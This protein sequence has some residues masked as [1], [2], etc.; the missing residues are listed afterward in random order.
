[1][2]PLAPACMS[3]A[4]HSLSD[5]AVAS[6]L[7][8]PVAM[9]SVHWLAEHDLKALKNGRGAPLAA[10]AL[11]SLAEPCTAGPP[12][13]SG[14]PHSP[15]VGIHWLVEHVCV[16]DLI[17]QRPQRV[18]LNITSRKGPTTQPST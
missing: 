14:L 12:G 5:I 10:F 13:S 8:M 3:L 7:L 11:A 4:G 1:M 16:D 17:L 15:Q 6:G 9:H 2:H 18:V